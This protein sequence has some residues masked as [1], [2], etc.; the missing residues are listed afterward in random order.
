MKATVTPVGETKVVSFDH[1]PVPHGCST[2]VGGVST[3][4]LESLNTG[5]TVGD[6][7]ANVWHN[8]AR[9]SKHLGVENLP[10]LLS[11]THGTEV[12]AV[13]RKTPVPTDLTSRPGTSY[14][15]D[16]CI[17]NV[18][19][20]PLSL[21]V[22]DCVPVFF[23][24]PEVRAVGVTHA[25]WRGT[26]NGIVK[27]TIECLTE[28]YGSDPANVRVGIGP[29]IGPEAFEVGAE[30]V[31]EFAAAFS[32]EN[33]VIRPHPDEELRTAGKAFVNLWEANRIMAMRAGVPEGLIKISG[34][35]TASHPEL[36]FSH[37]RDRGKSGRL[38]AGI[39]LD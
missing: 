24:D 15:A 32:E 12:V 5:F 4:H 19:G 38:L 7:P 14:E 39:V 16:G 31:E 29:S 34:W 9:F 3:G 37:R 21:T 2:R 13:Q 10:W 11:M 1:I 8:R 33:A 18:V 26:V 20:L 28:H 17:T 6:D 30:V 25:G 27:R 36:F 35:C 23:F 22:A